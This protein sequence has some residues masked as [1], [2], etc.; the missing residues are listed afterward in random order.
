[1]AGT[2][3][4]EKLY[5]ENWKDGEA[6]ALDVHTVSSSFLGYNEQ[7]TPMFDTKYSHIGELLHNFKYNKN[8]KAVDEIVSLALPYLANWS[9]N[10]SIIIPVPY[11]RA[12]ET[13]PVFLFA[14][15]LAK[16]LGKSV[17]TDLLAKTSAGQSKA[18]AKKIEIKATKNE[19][20]PST[21]LLV[22]DIFDTGAT[23]NAC[24]KVLKEKYKVKTVYVLCIT[25]TKNKIIRI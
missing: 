25:K 18:Q 1:M 22:D 13:Q 20:L 3:N 6:Y 9:K 19:E 11:T 2:V 15:K 8:L 17:R 4:P 5:S 24:V 10:F 14:E 21:V 12:R 7:G 16:A 23:L